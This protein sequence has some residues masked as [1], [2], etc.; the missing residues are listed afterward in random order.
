M[1]FSALLRFVWSAMVG[2]RFSLA[3]T[4]TECTGGS[5]AVTLPPPSLRVCAAAMNAPM[6]NWM[7]G[8]VLASS[9]DP[10][11]Q[12]RVPARQLHRAQ[13]HGQPGGALEQ[14]PPA[15]DTARGSV[16]SGLCL[17]L[18]VHCGIPFHSTASPAQVGQR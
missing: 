5:C 12:H 8:S 14:G 17:L 10:L 13:R 2:V 7:S 4:N 3:V 9:V 1:V 6:S 11:R 18:G 15:D 16:R